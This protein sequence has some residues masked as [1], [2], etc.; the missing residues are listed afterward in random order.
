MLGQ[1]KAF[2]GFSVSDLQEAKE[3]YQQKLG[4]KV[5]EDT[6]MSILRLNITGSN[7]IIVYPKPN[8]MPA[9]YTVLNFPVSDI[10]AAVDELTKRGVR[11]LQ[12]EGELKTDE[13]GIFRSDDKSRGP[14][15]AWF[16]DPAGNILSV[17]EE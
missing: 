1:T 4:L 2:S 9:T 10:D 7:D 12:Y 6:T 15:I 3:F 16:E 5:T 11:F 17:L 14:S 8:H 13:K